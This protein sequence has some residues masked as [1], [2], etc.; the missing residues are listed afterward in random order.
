MEPDFSNLTVEEL[1][2]ELA[3]LV[4]NGI[5]EAWS[6]ATIQV[7]VNNDDDVSF[8]PRYA[9]AGDNAQ[10]QPFRLHY[11]AFDLVIELRKRLQKPGA[12][13]FRSMEFTLERTGKFDL[14]LTYD[15]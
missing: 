5:H 7:T 11:T 15:A 12:A 1:Y 4:V 8:R 9:R 2:Q 6:S 14:Q 3:N 13:P 10:S